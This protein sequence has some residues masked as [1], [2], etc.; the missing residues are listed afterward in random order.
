MPAGV[1]KTI[2]RDTSRRGSPEAIEKRRAARRFN[3]LLASESRPGRLDGRTEK[4]RQ[5]LLKELKDG[6]LRASGKGLKPIDILQRID[7]LLALGEPLVALK[8]ALKPPRPVVSSDEVIAGVKQLHEAYGFRPEAYAFVG[9]DEATLRR[10]GVAKSGRAL[11]PKRAGLAS[12][13]RSGGAGRR[14]A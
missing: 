8:K 9:I 6:Q 12:A 5:R 13:S 14:A 2:R 11:G 10:A 3:D 4:K 7:E 1:K